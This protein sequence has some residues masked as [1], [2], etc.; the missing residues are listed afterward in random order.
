MLPFY[1]ILFVI[2]FMLLSVYAF[3]LSYRCDRWEEEAHRWKD[4]HDKVQ[5]AAAVIA[6]WLKE[7]HPAIWHELDNA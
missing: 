5:E 1:S 3:R 7:K 2:A 6:S 4:Q